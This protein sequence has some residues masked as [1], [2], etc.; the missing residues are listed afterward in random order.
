M[1]WPLVLIALSSFSSR[2]PIPA[3]PC[4]LQWVE[5]PP[6]IFRLYT[7]FRDP[8]QSRGD[9][10][11][12][13]TRAKAVTANKDIVRQLDQIIARLEA[14]QKREV[15]P[16]L[17]DDDV[18]K[19]IL[20]LRDQFEY[21]SF[22]AKAGSP[23]ARLIRKGELAIPALIESLDAAD[24]SRSVVLLPRSDQYHI[25]TVGDCAHGILKTITGRYFSDVLFIHGPN[26]RESASAVKS[27]AREWFRSR[28][29]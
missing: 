27:R 18:A 25:L 29:P 20:G 24:Y 22:V 10:C 7:T 16:R 26:A 1:T 14:T 21:E 28:N 6:S 3:G 12:L 4:D 11:R 13:A 5:E 9:L 23:A 8:T 19:M 15:E 2:E 17:K